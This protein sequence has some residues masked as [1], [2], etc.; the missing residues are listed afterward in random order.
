MIALH[1]AGGKA[2]MIHAGGEKSPKKAAFPDHAFVS[3]IIITPNFGQAPVTLGRDIDTVAS[4]AR[5]GTRPDSSAPQPPGLGRPGQLS[6]AYGSIPKQLR[7]GL[8][9]A[10]F[11]FGP[12][13]V[14]PRNSG[15]SRKG[16]LSEQSRHL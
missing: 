10:R 2:Q 8:S 14:M 13:T 9:P 15:A 7:A 11:L 12:S 1:G 4:K 16:N 3:A 5:F 6:F